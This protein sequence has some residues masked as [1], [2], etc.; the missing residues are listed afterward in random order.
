MRFPVGTPSDDAPGVLAVGCSNA[1]L[2]FVSLSARHPQGLDADYLAWHTLDHRPEQHRIRGLA[3][4][5]RFVSTPECR[6]ARAARSDRY[7]PVDHVMSYFFAGPESLSDFK[8]LG[9]ALTDVGRYPDRLPPVE[10]GTYSFAGKAAAPRIKVGA[11]VVLWWPARGLYLLIEEGHVPPDDLLSVRG[12]G[13]VWRGTRG[14]EQITFL[15]L[16][17]D[18]VETARLLAEPLGLRWSDGPAAPL[19]AAPFHTV[20][21]YDWTRHLP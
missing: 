16:D 3:A 4:S 2:V 7:D 19:L 5:R 8:R 9:T 10:R 11:D 1:N 17:D 6:A 13:G 12:V 20:V 14:P 18:P 21:P 15:Y